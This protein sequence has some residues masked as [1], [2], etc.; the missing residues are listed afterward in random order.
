MHYSQKKGGMMKMIIL[1]LLAIFLVSGNVFAQNINIRGKVIDKSGEP[2]IGVTV[3]IEGTRT[4]VATELDGT[5]SINAPANAVL[6]FTA[7]GMEDLKEQVNNRSLINVTMN[8]SSIFLED[9]VVTALGIKKERKALGYAVSDIKSEELMRNKTANPISSLSGKIAGVNITQSSGAA[10]SGAQIILRG[11]TSGSEGKDNQPLFVVDGVIYDNSSTLVGSSG[12]DGS[13]KA[14]TTTSNRIM[15]INPEDI[16]NMSILKGP[17]A[18]ALYGSRAANG[19]VIITTKKGKEGV[20]EVNINSKFS[21]SWVKSLPQVQ[22]EFTRGYME[23][24]YDNQQN[25]LGTVFNDFSYNSWGEKSNAQTYDNIGN[26]FQ[27][28]IVYDQSASVSGGT[29]NSN[30]YLSGSYYDQKGIVPKTG[31]DKFTFRFNGEQRAG[32]FTFN[33][34]AAYSQAHTDRTLT[35]AGLYGSQGTGALYGVYNWSPFDNVSNYLNEDGTRYR[36]FGER[37]D[38][39]E[40]RDNPYWIVNKNKM[41][42]NTDRFTGSLGVKAD[43]ADWWFVQYRLGIDSYTQINSNRIAANGVVKQVWQNGMM[44]DNTMRFKYMSHNFISNMNKKFGDFDFN[45]LLGAASDDTQTHSNFMM[46]WNFSVPDFYSYANASTENKQFANAASQKRLVGLFGEFRVAWKNILYM[47]VT[48][49]NDW[50]STLPIENRS[51]FYPSVSGSF[52]FTELLPKSS[53][54]TFGKIRAS[55]AKVGK[56]TGAYETNTSLWPVGTYL[57][58]KIGVGNSW[59]RGNPYLKPEMTK[60]TEIGVELSLLKDRLRVDYAYYTNDSYNQILSPRGPQST[61]YIFCSINA[62]NVYNKGME[63]TVTGT[64]VE[65]K[66]LKWD[67]GLNVAGNRGTLDGLPTGMDVMYVTD[68][69]YAGA[70]AA[71]FNG[72]NFMAIAGTEWKRYKYDPEVENSKKELDGKLILDANGMPTYTTSLSEVGNRE[73]KFSGGLNNTITWKGFSFNM[74]WEF[75]VGGDVINGTQ[76]AMT[77]SGVSK[78]S[79][80]VR[81]RELTVTGIDASGNAVSNTW[82]ADN[83]YIFNGVETSGHNIIKSYYTNYYPRETA[84]YIT[85]VNLLRLRTLSVMYDFPKR[86]LDRVGFIKRASISASANNL[87]L[88]TNYDGDPEVAASGAGVG[89]SSSV[90]FDYCGVPATSGMTFG[91]NLTF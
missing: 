2:L 49:R 73:T 37:L 27:G 62:G 82:S 42:D 60:S 90:G 8:E 91:L 51:Y 24:Q 23:D 11:G 36:L 39:W 25:Y 79:G 86:W 4:G 70:Q 68:V 63:L 32:I 3:V 87:L 20:V 29:K 10:G 14:A 69:Q 19:V 31:Y 74:L 15:D 21:T 47:T 52:V 28:G 89:G 41:Y 85:D 1:S 50:T 65:T 88:F 18:S 46:A 80:D 59:T 83:T 6:L 57:G 40:E 33:A 66:D 7:I 34:N 78:F 72:G 26:F 17:A 5:Y 54:L 71:S 55:W 56:D 9:V 35:G 53:I 77:N 84:N 38:P 76:Y 81:N 67:I 13:Y 58:G 45:L 43:I 44:S 64:P 48:G 61:G 22:N 12:F 30:F 75:R 16:E